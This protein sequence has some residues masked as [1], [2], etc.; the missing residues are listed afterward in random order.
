MWEVGGDFE[1]ALLDSICKFPDPRLA[2]L[3][4]QTRCSER[5]CWSE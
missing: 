4:I 2:Q 1:N 3:V 5:D